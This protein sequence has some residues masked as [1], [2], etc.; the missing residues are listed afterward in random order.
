MINPWRVHRA[1]AV[2]G[3]T[4]GKTIVLV[5][6]RPVECFEDLSKFEV[7]E[8]VNVQA[9]FSICLDQYV[10]KTVRKIKTRKVA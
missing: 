2:I 6:G 4:N 9:S 7:G 3:K 1:R 8:T 5:K 10:I